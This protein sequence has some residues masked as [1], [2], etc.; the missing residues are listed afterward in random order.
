MARKRLLVTLLWPGGP[1]FWFYHAGTGITMNRRY[2]LDWLRVIAFAILMLFHTG[3]AFSSYDWHVKNFESSALIDWLIVFFHQWRMPL[4]FFISGAAVWFAM[5]KYPT[6][7]YLRERHTRLLVPLLFGMLVVIPPQVYCERLYQRQTYSSFLDFYPTVF[8]SGS[9]PQ[10]NLSWHHLWYVPY[11]WAFSMITLPLFAWLR[12]TPGRTVLARLQR[13]LQSPVALFALFVPSAIIEILLRP[14]YPGDSNDLVSDWANFTHKLSFFVIGFILASTPRVSDTIAVHRR[15]FLL[16]ALLSLTA[17]LVWFSHRSSGPWT[18]ASLRCLSNFHTWMWVLAALGFGRKHLNFNH[19]FLRYSTDAVY[20]FY[21]L[22][23][24]V[25]VLLAMQIVYVDMG[26]WSKYFIILAGMSL[27]TWGLYELIIR[28]VNVLRI[29]FGLKPK[30]RPVAAAAAL[31]EGGPGLPLDGAAR[32]RLNP[33]GAEAARKAMLGVLAVLLCTS[34]APARQGTLLPVTFKAPSLSGNI[35]GVADAQ[36]AAVYLPASYAS[37]TNRYP[38]IYFLPNFDT[39][40]WRYTSG[41]FQRFRLRQAVDGLIGR[42]AMRET[43]VVIPNALHILGGSWYRNS[44]LT[45]NWED[46]IA[47]D[48]VR[49]MDGRFRTIPEARARGLAGHGIGGT[50]ALELALK[51]PDIFGAVY[52]MSPALLDEAGIKEF[53]AAGDAQ[54]PRWEELLRKWANLDGRGRRNEF[55]LYIQ[56]CLNSPSHAVHFDGLRLSCLAAGSP[57]L[58]LPYPHI[59]FPLP[60]RDARSS[61]ERVWGEIMGNWETKVAAYNRNARRL[62]SI[63]IEYGRDDEYEWIRR[64]SGYVSRL[65]D[66]MGVPNTLTVS[67]G[68]HDGTLGARL[69]T[70]MLPRL[71]SALRGG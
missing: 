13:F 10:G 56:K 54:A 39:P 4:L 34:S 55:R 30:H 44:R 28:R 50:G 33:L 17:L 66:T 61:R 52:A 11:I 1:R 16:A 57:D 5:E 15:K 26:L 67:D 38:V 63:T 70:G 58:S 48:V 21:I 45:G 31:A 47:G 3:M 7:R 8:T 62:N 60:Q 41:A 9:Y 23:Q 65:L 42:G 40:I 27:I 49:F 19:R 18:A 37:G 43:I 53:T 14:F 2:D 36:P 71:S 35:M 22:H 64:G 6:W 46:Y 59:A 24:T 29:C 25:I 12:S 32:A 20:P 51:H 68:G 69:E